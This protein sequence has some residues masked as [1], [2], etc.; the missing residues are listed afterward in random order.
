M[1]NKQFLKTAYIFLIGC[2]AVVTSA[3]AQEKVENHN[4][5]LTENIQTAS[6][7]VENLTP[8]PSYTWTDFITNKDYCLV[9]IF[10]FSTYFFF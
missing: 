6:E 8:L 10:I 4:I 7:E 5:I 9:F 3:V 1:Q 2:M